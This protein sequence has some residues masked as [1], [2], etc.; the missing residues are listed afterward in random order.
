MPHQTR[1]WGI[2]ER[3]FARDRCGKYICA[4]SL[5]NTA[6][7]DSTPSRSKLDLPKV[8]R[9]LR[10]LL[11]VERELSP[12]EVDALC[13]LRLAIRREFLNYQLEKR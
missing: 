12:T 13:E 5:M 6:S 11:A 2:L 1:S 8:I 10:R 3:P 4:W 9:E 7:S